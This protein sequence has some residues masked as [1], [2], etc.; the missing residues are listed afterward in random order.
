[1][2]SGKKKNRIGRQLVDT[3][4]TIQSQKSFYFSINRT[5]LN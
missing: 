4:N 1:M 5:G 2:T 3:V